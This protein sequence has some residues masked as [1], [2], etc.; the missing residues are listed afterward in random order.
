MGARITAAAVWRLCTVAA[1]LSGCSGDGEDGV[2]IKQRLLGTWAIQDSLGA[3][4]YT[5]DGDGKFEIDVVNVVGAGAQMEVYYG[6]FDLVRTEP[7]R[8]PNTPDAIIVDD[9]ANELFL[10]TT[11][12]T[13]SSAG[14]GW[15]FTVQFVGASGLRLV[16]ETGATVLERVAPADNVAGGVV[17]FGCFLDSGFVESPL[18]E[19][20]PG[21]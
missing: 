14:L 15:I 7:A 16:T 9:N 3:L 21:R 13:C 2:T 10:M 12:S 18:Q 6:D 19:L 1:A 5:F 17:T 8:Y 4:A 11:H 20:D